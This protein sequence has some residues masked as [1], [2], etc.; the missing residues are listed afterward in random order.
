MSQSRASLRS[1][2]LDPL[3]RG[4]G[5]GVRKRCESRWKAKVWALSVDEGGMRPSTR[6]ALLLIALLPACG[7]VHPLETADGG[8]DAPA[9][10]APPTVDQACNDLSTSLCN[11]L[12]TCSAFILQLGFGDVSTCVSRNNLSCTIS[13]NAS[14]VGRTVADIEACARALPA[15]T[16]AD[17]VAHKMPAACQ[18]TPGSVV[19]GLACGAST[20]CQST[21]CRPTGQCGVCA[22]RQTTGAACTT[23]DQC[24]PGLVCASQSCVAPGERSQG[25]DDKHPCRDDLYCST[26][27]GTGTGGGTCAMKLGAGRSC[28]DSDKACDIV[29]G[30]ACNP[31]SKLCQMVRVAHRGETCGLS[32]GTLVLCEAAGSCDGATAATG[33]CSA[34]AADG[35]SCGSATANNRNCL[36][37]ASCVAGIC[38]LPATPS[39]S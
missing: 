3:P 9:D 13:Q 8:G 29:Q 31:V 35:E 32:G 5:R 23:T 28:A 21:Y 14:G 4:R 10:A 16:C 19:N 1:P 20:Q 33:T 2:L 12:N 25:C 36:A 6:F 22:P 37:P 24:E 26:S 18:D 27:S 34:A 17:L 30:V 38:R 39:C 11:A 15:S 7:E